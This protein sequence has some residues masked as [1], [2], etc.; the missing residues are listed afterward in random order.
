V[1]A[2]EDDRI[3]RLTPAEIADQQVGAERLAPGVWRDRAGGIHF[4]IPELLAEFELED[5]PENQRAV[6]A[7]L[8]ETI[9]GESLITLQVPRDE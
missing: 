4:S 5:T 9:D 7:I 2:P 1:T 3:V 8:L 6:V